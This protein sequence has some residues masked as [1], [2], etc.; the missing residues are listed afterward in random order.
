MY[1]SLLKYVLPPVLFTLTQVV[2]FSTRRLLRRSL[3]LPACGENGDN[4]GCDG[5]VKPNISRSGDVWLMLTPLH[6]LINACV[7]GLKLT[8]KL[9]VMACKEP[10]TDVLMSKLYIGHHTQLLT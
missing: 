5:K 1:F 10:E 8:S 9:A 7:G 3:R 4:V 6:V 2:L